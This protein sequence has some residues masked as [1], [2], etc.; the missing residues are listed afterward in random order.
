MEP[1][2]HRECFAICCTVYEL[3]GATLSLESK[4]IG[5][6]EFQHILWFFQTRSLQS[7]CRIQ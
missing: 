6:A 3:V 5:D 2:P 4:T 7:A 1:V